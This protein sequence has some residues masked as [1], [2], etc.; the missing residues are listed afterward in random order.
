MKKNLFYLFALIC[1]VSL[2]TA[3][4]DDDDDTPKF[5]KD[6]V[7]ATYTSTD[8]SNQ[9]QLLYSGEPMLGKSVTFNTT[10]GKTATIVLKGVAS[11]LTKA[12]AAP[13]GSGVIPGETSTTLNVT[14]EPI[15]ETGYTFKGTDESNGRTVAYEGSVEKGKLALQLNVTMATNDLVGTW[16][17]Y[18]YDD[19]PT[20]TVHPL[21][22]VW[23]STNQFEV[24]L[25]FPMKLNPGDLLTLTSAIGLIGEGKDK[26]NL[27]E[28]ISA[29]LKDVTFRPDG[30]IQA[31]YSEAANL[32]SPVWKKSPLNLVQY[33]VKNGKI[34]VYL[35]IDAILATVVGN[36]PSS[37]LDITTILPQ[38]MEL[39]PMVYNGIPLGYSTSEDGTLGV[40]IEK[41]LG[42]QLLTMFLPLLQDEEV[43]ATIMEAVNSNP[44]FGMFA[45][46]MQD[47]LK[48]LPAAV[49]GTTK[50]ELG[51]NFVE[52]K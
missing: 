33:S 49:A 52:A 14:L 47:L 43:L 27:Q 30:N 48:Q 7:N 2:F 5:P 17:L 51:L 16:N 18:P 46:I 31:S 20:N 12:T 6:E 25:G 37:R 21:R 10:D 22:L 15:G 39:L 42:V 50:M 38:L 9:L 36:K 11:S 8:A 26:L 24:N 41:D 34:I 45:G 4:S 28:A 13:A 19:T 1:S 35:N 44:D 23:D 40:Y 3:C 29:V 32:G